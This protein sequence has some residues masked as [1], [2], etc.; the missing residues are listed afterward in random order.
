MTTTAISQAT[1]TELPVDIETDDTGLRVRW[2]GGEV[3]LH[4]DADQLRQ[5]I[6]ALSFCYE[7]GFEEASNPR[8]FV[9]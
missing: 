9:P 8:L 4:G 7:S 6:E 2:D 5:Y 1:K 3:M